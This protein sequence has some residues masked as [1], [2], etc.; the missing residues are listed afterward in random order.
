MPSLWQILRS[1]LVLV[2]LPCAISSGTTVSNLMAW[3]QCEILSQTDSNQTLPGW[4][5]HNIEA[6]RKA[7][8]RLEIDTNIFYSGAGSLK[9]SGPGGISLSSKP[10][11]IIADKDYVLKLWAKS[12]QNDRK[13]SVTY[14]FGNL[15]GHHT[16]SEQSLLATPAW[17]EYAF[18]LR[19]PAG[20]TQV[21]VRLGLGVPLW[22]DDVTFGEKPQPYP[23]EEGQVTTVFS[24]PTG[25]TY[26][27]DFPLYRLAMPRR[28]DLGFCGLQLL[29][30]NDTIF[31]TDGGVTI[32]R[33][34]TN[35]LFSAHD[36]WDNFIMTETAGV[37]T[38][39]WKAYSSPVVDYQGRLIA[40]PRKIS[41]HEEWT[42]RQNQHG[43]TC[44]YNIPLNAKLLN[45]AQY[46]VV[47]RS[48]TTRLRQLDLTNQWKVLEE[49]QGDGFVQDILFYTEKIG[50]R[51]TFSFLN[52][53]IKGC[54]IY[55]TENKT[56]PTNPNLG[57]A[58]QPVLDI[59][60]QAGETR[61]WTVE[62]EFPE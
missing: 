45:G 44:W 25:F 22:I 52:I 30:G 48:G 35:R 26:W 28:S 7:G 37:K 3:G 1:M 24:P 49:S 39:T 14:D 50:L 58:A 9:L 56:D 31:K 12:D 29:H 53:P 18:A 8:G 51:Y 20:S 33:G 54:R 10:I 13:I 59:G 61:G 17:Q 57:I 21:T 36:V 27:I 43:I 5:I 16:Y 32:S 11:P 2:L 38:I 41:L 62:I 60:G 34:D 55:T 19:M 42:Y 40:Q 47:Y 46:V 4:Y 6:F 15:T 23:L